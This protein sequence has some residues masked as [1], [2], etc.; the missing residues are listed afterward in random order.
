MADLHVE[1]A[2][3]KLK[4]PV[5]AASGTFGSGQEY[6]EF[7]DLKRLGAIVTKT[8]TLKEKEGNLP[9][10]LCETPCGI[11]NSIG[12][13][14]KGVD[15]FIEQELPWLEEQNVPLI[16][17]FGGTTLREYLEVAAVLSQAPSISAFE[18]NISCPNIK[19]GGMAFGC[20]REKASELVRAVRKIVNRPLIVKLTP[21]VTDIVEIAKACEEAGADAL[22]LINTVL[23]MA[24]DIETFKPKLATFTGG[25]SGPAIRPIAVRMVW[26]TAQ[27]VNVPIIGMGGITTAENAVEFFLAGATAVAVGTAN[28]TDP[29]TTLD[30][31][32]GLDAWLERK[33]I[34]SIKSLIG[35]LKIGD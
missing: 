9:P 29:R 21:N 13:Q 27:A 3:I 16:V 19:A 6:S 32:A 26:Q 2:G 28:F 11:L 31:I 33:G 8:L 10:R 25:L 5:M 14:N 17:S 1:I 12:L 34:K 23:G 7:V 30:I 4:N 35:R 24:I 18:L 15:Y 20:S 22:S